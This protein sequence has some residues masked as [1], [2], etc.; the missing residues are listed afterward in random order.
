M[1]KLTQE[2]IQVI[3]DSG[4]FDA[5]WY[6]KKYPDVAL[7]GLDFYE[8]YLK[9]G[10][11]LGRVS[12]PKYNSCNLDSNYFKEQ[13]PA[14]H[15]LAGSKSNCILK[16]EK[17]NS[18]VIAFYLPQFHRV[19]EN[20]EWWGPGFTEWTNVAKAKPNYVGH[21]QPKIPR[22]LGFYDLTEPNIIQEQIEMAK[23]YGIS[24]FCFYYYW[25][26]GR[27]IL[28][29]PLNHFLKSNFNF[30]FTICWANENWTRTWD[31]SSKNILLHQKYQEQDACHFIEAIAPILSDP[32]YV[33]IN[34]MPILL[35]YRA[36]E[37]PEPKKWFDLWRKRACELGLNGIHI[38][39]VDFY[40]INTPDEVGADSLVEFPPHKFIG[41]KNQPDKFP[42]LLNKNFSGGIVDYR[43]VVI[44]SI[45]KPFQKFAYFRGIIPSWDNTARRQDTSMMLVN[46]RPEIFRDWLSYLRSYTRESGNGK[47]IFVNAWNEWA[48]GCVLE[49]DLGNGL[50]YLE[51]VLRTSFY[52]PIDNIQKIRNELQKKLEESLYISN[53][54]DNLYYDGIRYK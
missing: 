11:K 18:T 31:G 50:S 42:V 29:K 3:K 12:A 17:D 6:A 46:E 8:H 48:E 53:S 2:K 10:S 44:Q 47:L 34:N 23:S 30:N 26:S 37:I 51:E 40:D 9:I 21:N 38:A 14:Y 15:P 1:K 49:P 27:R 41:P 43:K 28:E 36:K 32:R 7:S 20:S 35:V 25:F 52:S 45:N 13:H 22:E 24:A 54:S 4:L 16:K 39:C 5:E 19:T 33:T